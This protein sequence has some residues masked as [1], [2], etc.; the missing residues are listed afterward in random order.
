MENF[1]I[2]KFISNLLKERLLGSFNLKSHFKLY[3]G[4]ILLKIV[5]FLKLDR[6]LDMDQYFKL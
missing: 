3:L 4:S 6:I 5:I 1:T 2:K